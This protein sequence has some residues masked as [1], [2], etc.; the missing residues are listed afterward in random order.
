MTV[1]ELKAQLESLRKAVGSSAL[2]VRSGEDSITSRSISEILAAIRAVELQI[3]ILEAPVD[4]PPIRHI[5]V[6]AEKGL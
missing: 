4:E 5:R 1:D 3:A 6:Y 2:T